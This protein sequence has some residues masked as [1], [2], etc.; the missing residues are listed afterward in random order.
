[1]VYLIAMFGDFLLMRAFDA[2]IGTAAAEGRRIMKER[3]LTQ[4]IALIAE[5]KNDGYHQGVLLPLLIEE[6]GDLAELSREVG[7]API[8]MEANSKLYICN[9]GHG[10]LKITTDRFGYNNLDSSW[11]TQGNKLAIIGDSFAFGMCQPNSKTIAG[12]LGDQYDTLNL[13]FPGANAVHYAAMLKTFGPKIGADKAVMIFYSNDNM[14]I[15]YA[16]LYYDL[17]FGPH[18]DPSGYFDDSVAMALAPSHKKFYEIAQARV[19]AER[20]ATRYSGTGF[21]AR[22]LRRSKKVLS[23][24]NFPGVQAVVHSYRRTLEDATDSINLAVKTLKNHCVA[25]ACTPLILYIP[26]SQ[27]WDPDT[28]SPDFSRLVA[29]VSGEYGIPIIDLTSELELLGREKAY[30]DAGIHLSE[31]GYAV[32]ADAVINFFENDNAALD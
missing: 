8:G 4:D 29:E 2:K 32:V 15:K 18:A 23:H 30:A 3:F 11:D 9:E 17:F 25:E 16:Q 6:T 27:F 12:Y 24:Y 26:N 13:S 7:F 20:Q 5:A 1:M 21:L 28:R 10:P 22:N 19:L 31:V 14:P